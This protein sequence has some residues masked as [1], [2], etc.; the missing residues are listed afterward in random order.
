ML[1][2]LSAE[3]ASHPTRLCN[4]LCQSMNRIRIRNQQA[5]EDLVNLSVCQHS[6]WVGDTRR[7]GWRSIL[8]R[9]RWLIWAAA[10]SGNWSRHGLLVL[11]VEVSNRRLRIV[12]QQVVGVELGMM[13]ASLITDDCDGYGKQQ[14]QKNDNQIAGAD[15]V[16]DFL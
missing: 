16:C 4:F 3:W 13:Y 15:L 8:R 12:S 11:C 14:P 6:V 7:E 2:W 9:A 1:S 10:W 5:F